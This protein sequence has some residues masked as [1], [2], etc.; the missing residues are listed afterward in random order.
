MTLAKNSYVCQKETIKLAK[1]SYE[2]S[3]KNPT[4]MKLTIVIVSLFKIFQT[5]NL[6]LNITSFEIT[7]ICVLCLKLRCVKHT[8]R[9]LQPA[10]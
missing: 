6:N 8:A 1:N 10:C 4:A 2:V 9:G 5:S 3:Q 7:L